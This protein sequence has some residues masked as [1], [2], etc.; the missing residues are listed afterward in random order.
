[1]F[2]KI[3]L[4]ELF[5]S[6]DD[7]CSHFEPAWNAETIG[8]R[9]LK[10]EM[11]M[12]EILTIIILFQTSGFRCFKY[13]YAHI[14]QHHRRD[15]PKILS[16]TRF[17]EIK[18]RYIIPL[19][20]FFNYNLGECTGISYVDSTPLKICH[21]KRIYQHK[22]FKDIA[23]R[24]KSTMGWFF[25][26]KLHIVT[27]E[28]G[29]LLAAECTQGNVDD[30]SVIQNLC[31]SVKGIMF[32]DRGYISE[33]LFQEMMEKGLR[34][35]TALRAK[36]KPMLMTWND[37]ELLKK[38]SMIESVFHIFKDMLHVDHT[39]HRSHANFIVNILGALCAYSIYPNKPGI[40][41]GGLKTADASLIV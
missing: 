32:G 27:N 19:T 5:C 25:G 4:V 9:S 18:R 38:R 35:V 6:V 28:N 15:F 33:K 16:Y 13:F 24:G 11:A 29:E 30:R 39:R 37:S 34:I 21:N 12:S 41:I 7:F 36:M 10:C 22:V 23:K 14:L 26:F 40:R 20:M 17:V 1:M 8:D 31:K 2:N 3:S